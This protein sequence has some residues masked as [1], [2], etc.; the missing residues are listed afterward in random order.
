MT[1][2]T[3]PAPRTDNRSLRDLQSRWVDLCDPSVDEVD[4]HLSSDVDHLVRAQLHK[5]SHGSADQVRPLLRGGDS[6]VFG[7][8]L[9]PVLENEGELAEEKTYYQEVDVVLTRRSLLTVRKVAGSRGPAYDPLVARGS[10]RDSDCLGTLMYHL[11]DDIAER[12]VDLVDRLTEEIEEVE[13]GIERWDDRFVRRRISQLRHDMLQIRRVLSPTRDGLR[14]VLDGRVDLDGDEI[15]PRDVELVFNNVYE[16]LL[17]ASEGL[18]LARDLLAGVR[19]YHQGKIANDQNDVMKRLTVIASVLLL[20]TFIV[21]LYG[22]N[23]IDMPEVHWLW[24]YA[25]SWGLIGMSTVGQIMF[26]KWRKWI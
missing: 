3:V 21:G 6:Y 22:Q 14:A 1:A 4:S 11:V 16:K 15:F 5:R 9:V 10:C 12:F 2:P 26:F 23:F 25:W 24:G 8:F 20:P 7:V 17:R 19:D 13:D 18:E